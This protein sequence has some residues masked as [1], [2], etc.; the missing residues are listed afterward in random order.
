LK[1]FFSELKR[2][3]NTAGT[4]I[5]TRAIILIR[6]ATPMMIAGAMIYSGIFKAECRS[7][8]FWT[9]MN[10]EFNFYTDDG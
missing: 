1:I 2:G 10:V 8:L 4:P 6:I 9:K 7:A 3:A 5:V